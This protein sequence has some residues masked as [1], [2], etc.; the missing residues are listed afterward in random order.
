MKIRD[1]ESG[2]F[3]Q[4]LKLKLDSKEEERK[5]N[6]E[7]EPV[8]KVKK[9]YAEYL[10]NDLKSAYRKLLVATDK[11]DIVGVI[12]VKLFRSLKVAGYKKRG[13]LSNLYVVP[14]Y[15]KQGVGRKLTAKAI[16]WLKSVGADEATLEIYENNLAARMLYEK[17]GFTTYSVKMMKRI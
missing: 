5:L 6:K 12:L 16:S 4:L 9:H 17:L 10:N 15:R 13:Y 7:L 8:A 2:D 11:S 14:E 3:E 1:A